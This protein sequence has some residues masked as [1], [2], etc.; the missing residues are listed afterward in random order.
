MFI[1]RERV[2]QREA[3]T[4]IKLTTIHTGDFFHILLRDE[5]SMGMCGERGGGVGIGK[6]TG[7]TQT[8]KFSTPP[9]QIEIPGKTE[10]KESGI[11]QHRY[12]P[13]RPA[14]QC[15][16]IQSQSILL[17]FPSTCSVAYEASEIKVLEFPQ[18][19]F[20]LFP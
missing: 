4:E 11:T 7:E 18:P 13:F 19:P 16:P 14:A 9:I 10:R 20:Q 2:R 12:R 6:N 15:W 3:E 1:Q 5:I 17:P 8:G